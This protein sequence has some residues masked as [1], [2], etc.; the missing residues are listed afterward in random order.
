MY[1]DTDVVSV[2]TNPWQEDRKAKDSWLGLP[3]LAPPPT[4]PFTDPGRAQPEG[5][6]R[7]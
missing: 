7:L 6:D 3:P 4:S 2:S 1:Q 5:V